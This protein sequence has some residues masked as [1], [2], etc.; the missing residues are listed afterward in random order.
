MKMVTMID[1]LTNQKKWMIMNKIL[2]IQNK[3]MK[4]LLNYNQRMNILLKSR[5]YSGLKEI[6]IRSNK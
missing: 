1:M 5:S 4:S 6:E 2:K 3:R